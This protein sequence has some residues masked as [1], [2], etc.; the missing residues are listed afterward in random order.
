VEFA[1]LSA[2]EVIDVTVFVKS[3]DDYWIGEIKPS[4]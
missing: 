3:D 1:K 2:G 4:K